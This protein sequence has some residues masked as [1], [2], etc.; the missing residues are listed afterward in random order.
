AVI[1]AAR[2]LGG[3][4]SPVAV[5]YQGGVA[6]HCPLLVVKMRERLEEE[7]PEARVQSPLWKPVIGAYLLACNLVGWKAA[8]E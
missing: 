2:R 8:L 6:E 7:L 1:A 4:R 3:D 5:S